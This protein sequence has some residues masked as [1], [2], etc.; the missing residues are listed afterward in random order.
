MWRQKQDILQTK[1]I[2]VAAQTDIGLERKT[3]QDRY[4]M[5]CFS[6]DTI[7]MAIADGLGGEP[8]GEIASAYVMEEVKQLADMDYTNAAKDLSSFFNRMDQTLARF[9]I[10]EGE[11]IKHQA[12]QHYSKDVIDQCIGCQDLTPE[13]GKIQLK[14][15]DMLILASDG[16]YRSI[17]EKEICRIICQF[18]KPDQ[19][20]D[21]LIK[22]S[23]DAGGKDNITVV[24]G[25][26]H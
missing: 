22:L 4:A 23:L 5:R 24:I 20:A 18:P 21:A 11:L 16:L 19:A 17:T 12:K 15:D 2:E 26:I 1:K 7:L 10:Q 14:P 9:L 8:G 6:D 13:S 25:K 3:N